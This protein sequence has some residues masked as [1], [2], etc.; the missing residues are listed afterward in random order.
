MAQDYLHKN[1]FG[2]YDTY[3]YENGYTKT[4]IESISDKPV[5]GISEE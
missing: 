1:V 5:E 3:T 4:S 2:V